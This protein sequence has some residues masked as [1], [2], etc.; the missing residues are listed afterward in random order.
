MNMY[1]LLV[2]TLNRWNLCLSRDRRQTLTTGCVPLPL[3]Q[4]GV[5]VFSSICAKKFSHRGRCVPDVCV[6]V[7]GSW[8]AGGAIN[9]FT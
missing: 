1:V 2:I 7:F 5:S 3:L 6:A 4:S 9:L 8:T